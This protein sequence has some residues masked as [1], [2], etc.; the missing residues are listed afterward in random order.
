MASGSQGFTSD[1]RN[2]TEGLE[3]SSSAL[4]LASHA[5][6][7]QPSDINS[8]F[9]SQITTAEV[10]HQATAAEQEEKIQSQLN[11]F[12]FQNSPVNGAKFGGMS[13]ADLY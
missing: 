7:P 12:K 9:K 10:A 6:M 13:E 8:A 3:Y 4:D 5:N 2:L 1:G 11:E